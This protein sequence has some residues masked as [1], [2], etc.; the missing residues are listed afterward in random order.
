[1]STIEQARIKGGGGVT[2]QAND[3][4]GAP[5]IDIITDCTRIAHSAINISS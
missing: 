4:Q 2:C 1:V 5:Q 3:K